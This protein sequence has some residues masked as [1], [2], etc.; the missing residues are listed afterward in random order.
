MNGRAGKPVLRRGKVYVPDWD[1]PS[2]R[3]STVA[4]T[5]G[6]KGRPIP[7]WGIRFTALLKMAVVSRERHCP[8]T[9]ETLSPRNCLRQLNPG[10]FPD[11]EIHQCESH[12]TRSVTRRG[13]FTT[14]A[15]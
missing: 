3:G 11:T 8:H 6:L 7:A 10:V 13:T 5:A 12:S 15:S 2:F 14:T 4:E 1:K 9:D